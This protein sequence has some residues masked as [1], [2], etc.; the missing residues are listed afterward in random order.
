MGVIDVNLFTLS[1]CCVLFGISPATLRVWLKDAQMPFYPHPTDARIR[2]LTAEQVEQLARRSAGLSRSSPAFAK[3]T[4]R[5]RVELQRAG[6]GAEL[7]ETLA[8][9]ETQMSAVQLHLTE[10]AQI[11]LRQ[12]ETGQEGSHPHLL[13]ELCQAGKKAEVF[14]REAQTM[15]MEHSP[16]LSSARSL[17]LAELR[18][19]SHVLSPLIHYEEASETYVILDPKE[20]ELRLQPDSPAWFDWLATLSCFRFAGKCGRFSAYRAKSRRNPS[21]CWWAQRYHAKHWHK[22]YLGVTDHL[23]VATFERVAAYLQSLLS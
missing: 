2:C 23:T 16:D 13:A 1:E 11:V 3:A 20:P 21:H 7:Q 10:L 19:R 17:H 8:H 9:L 15:P 6:E 5:A 14:P 12:M 22:S 4:N 18:H